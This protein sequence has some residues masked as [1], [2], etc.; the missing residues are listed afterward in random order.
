MCISEGIYPGETCSICTKKCFLDVIETINLSP[1]LGEESAHH[2]GENVFPLHGL[3]V[4]G[5]DSITGILDPNGT[6]KVTA[7]RVLVGEMVP[8]LGNY[9][10]NLTW[11]VVL[12]RFRGTEF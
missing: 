8:D 9:D 4:P 5:A 1:E 2:Y 10:D 12:G 11:E 7:V 3:P 6:E